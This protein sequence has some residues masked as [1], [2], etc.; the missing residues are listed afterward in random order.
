[1]NEHFEVYKE[2]WI[3]GDLEAVLSACAEDFVY[4]DPIDGRMDK[5][6][7]G[8]YFRDLTEGGLVVTEVIG[9][10]TG[11]DEMVWCWWSSDNWEGAALAKVGPQ[12]LHW[13]KITYYAREPN[14]VAAR[15]ST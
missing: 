6:Q 8:A 4:D 15:S 7:F 2:G 5:A 10:K 12:G 1:M 9:E 3:K 13:Q 14:M 11:D